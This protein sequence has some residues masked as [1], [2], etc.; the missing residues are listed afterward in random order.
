MCALF[1]RF[2]CGCGNSLWVLG[3][4]CRR[5][6]GSWG[7][8]LV[9]WD[10]APG[11][12]PLVLSRSYCMC[13]AVLSFVQPQHRTLTLA[14]QFGKRNSRDI[15]DRMRKKRRKRDERPRGSR[16]N[17]AISGRS[18]RAPPCRHSVILCLVGPPCSSKRGPVE[19]GP[20][21]DEQGHGVLV[22]HT[23]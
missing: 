3:W 6:G 23:H 4:A 16:L 20:L 18:L 13:G 17:G 21:L 5:G 10:W 9:S 12:D 11:L 22:S 2:S 7:V 8:G 15:S 1:G 19:P 14:N